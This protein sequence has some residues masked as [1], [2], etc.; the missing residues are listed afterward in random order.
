MTGTIEIKEIEI[1][2]E[3]VIRG[4]KMTEAED[5][6]EEIMIGIE[7][8]EETEIM[9]GRGIEK[10]SIMAE[11]GIKIMNIDK[12]IMIEKEMDTEK[13][14]K[15][16]MMRKTLITKFVVISKKQEEMTQKK[17]KKWK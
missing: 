5:T 10:E 1:M 2:I 15:E 14:N 13:D 3:T 17:H 6:K 8:T 16:C 9:I 7:I 4:D 11:V 12:E